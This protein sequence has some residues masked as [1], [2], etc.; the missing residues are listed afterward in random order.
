MSYPI[1]TSD[2][3]NAL[4]DKAAKVNP[5]L[6]WC[7]NYEP[8]FPFAI[9]E[10]ARFLASIQ[11]LYKFSVDTGGMLKHFDK[12]YIQ[13]PRSIQEK[14]IKK[15][16]LV[17]MLR[18]FFDHNNHNENGLI[19][20]RRIDDFKHWLR[21]I[22][23]KDSPE[24]PEDFGKLNNILCTLAQD[25]IDLSD[26]MIQFAIDNPSS[27]AI[28]LWQNH[29]LAWYSNPSH[30]DIYHGYLM[31]AYISKAARTRPRTASL[32]LHR[33]KGKVNG[34]ISARVDRLDLDI[35]D[36]EQSIA[37]VKANLKKLDP[38]QRKLVEDT[39]LPQQ[40][41]KLRI[42]RDEF[43]P[44]LSSSD[45]DF[46]IFKKSLKNQLENTIAI[47]KS[48]GNSINLLPQHLFQEDISR[49]F[50]NV[51]SPDGDF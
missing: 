14:A 44:Y 24:T 29:I 15:V 31:S 8:T 9:S 12:I 35:Q 16:E 48:Q 38:E 37:R 13:F 27:K 36:L 5:K 26:Q 10:D 46:S 42:M 1:I 17:E 47:A 21:S 51:S 41:A 45:S 40:E 33:I 19:E 2:Q 43:Q 28:T 11:D 6:F 49:V 34:W 7:C 30:F 18:H 50:A 4:N 25:L 39:L 22:V 32:P 3:V 20:E 23:G